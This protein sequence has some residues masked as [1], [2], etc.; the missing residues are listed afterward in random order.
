MIGIKMTRL[1]LAVLLAS[2]CQLAQAQTNLTI[3]YPVP[4]TISA[5]ALTPFSGVAIDD[6]NVGATSDVVSISLL[7]SA[8]GTLA[9]PKLTGSRPLYTLTTT[10]STINADLA[11]LVYTPS[12]LNG[13]SMLFGIS[14]TSSQVVMT[15]FGT[16]SGALEI[17][18]INLTDETSYPAPT[19]T[20]TPV[21]FKGVNIA[22]AENNYPSSSQ[23][24]YIYPQNVEIDYWASKGMGLIRMP[25]QIRRIQPVS[26][27]LLDPAGR[28]DEPAVSGSTPGTQ[29]NL[30][31][32]KRVLDHACADNVW[33]V[34]EPHNFGS[35]FDTTTNTNRQIGSGA[36]RSG[37]FK[38]WGS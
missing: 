37:G 19:C 18:N 5:G 22:G 16:V 21:N 26:Y 30:L 33:V 31:E 7:G 35:I 38:E 28:T 8:G 25:L 15:T 4:L 12:V 10:P 24:N 6:L 36:E 9:G 20:F 34:I 29:T 27:A 11:A 17:D 2:I 32:M 1:I 13:S 14:V 3:S 23:F